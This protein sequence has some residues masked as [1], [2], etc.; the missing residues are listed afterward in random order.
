MS[1]LLWAAFALATP[2]F[3]APED[4]LDAATRPF[5][6]KAVSE[7]AAGR[8]GP[9]GQLYRMVLTSDPG[10]LPA[11]LGLGRSL[12]AVGDT[13][14]AEALYRSL[15][16][17][18]DAVEA[19]AQ[20][21]EARDPAEALALWRRLR[22]LRLG[23]SLPYRE[24]ARLLAGTEPLAAMAAY[25]TYVRLL[26]GAT[27]HG[28]T[29]LALGAALVDAGL[30]A[31][32]EQRWRAYLDAFPAGDVALEVGARLDRLEVERAA[33]S[34]TIGGSEP[35]PPEVLPRYAAAQAAMAAGD[36]DDAAEEG[37]A[38][39]AAAPRSAVAHALLAD[40]LV[41]L[42]AWEE[43]EVHAILACAL[44]P[45]DPS[46]RVRLGL[47]LSEAY[48]GRRDREAV[49][50]L[51]EAAVLR[52]GDT[53]VQL[54]LGRLEQ[55][56]GS[57]DPEGYVRAQA[58]YERALANGASGA[59]AAEIAAR[60]DA[61]RHTPPSPPDVPP[62]R[63]PHLPAE[64]LDH[65][66][67][68]SVYGRRGR[69]AE[70]VVELDAALAISPDAP[71]LLNKRAQL[72]GLSGAAVEP[73]LIRSL[74]ADP[75]QPSVLLDLAAIAHKRGDAAGAEQRYAQAAR[76]GSA[77]AHYELAALAEA[78]DDWA[79]VREQLAAYE[80]AAPGRASQKAPA[81]TRL[82]ERADARLWALRA[83]FGG[84]FALVVGLP[85]LFWAR[86]RTARTLRDLLDTAPE[87]W[88][89]A[90]RLL[91][92]L[93]HEVLKH[94][95]TVLPAVAEALARG[96]TAPWEAFSARAPT[97]LAHFRSYLAQLEALGRRHGK[98]LDLRRR[99][100]I[101]GPMHTALARLAR[102]RRPPRADDLHAL[103]ALINGDGYQ[104]IGRLVREI[105]VLPVTPER[106][107]DV[108]KRIVTEP[109][110]AGAPVPALGVVE[111]EQGLAV[112]MFRADFEDILANVLRNALAAGAQRLDV[113]LG[114]FDDPVT[115]HAWVEV[116]VVDDAP[117]S[118]T[119]AMIRGRYIGRGLGLAVDLIN[120]HGGSIRVDARP[121]GRKAVV[122][123]L[124][125]VE[126]A[127][128]E[129]EEWTVS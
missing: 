69:T 39:I 77:D 22:T 56:L 92:A 114:A 83:G 21:V 80:A 72:A 117:G 118:L 59:T 106:A 74:E 68:A 103:S 45:D 16:D 42:R 88:H 10:F 30:A 73:W 7:E 29:L 128:V 61:L 105:C 11:S 36:L 18:A 97:L 48:G 14:A 28:P 63:A 35:L 78:R 108:Y 82:R 1:W 107:Q 8:A 34:L 33:E 20:L 24:E 85:L 101:L 50:E 91:A 122:V 41:A 90:A 27:P 47:L 3:A 44:A 55:A 2:A 57:A 76:L 12:E 96:D 53:E 123:Q 86:Y 100:P 129:V 113:E 15:G 119:N 120:R 99:D 111:R 13:A 102:T 60:L 95:T 79:V 81:A 98:R 67:I 54:V 38:L 116:A 32:A 62:S 5:F 115:G 87:C 75:D 40:V 112:R 93:R 58:A 31:D 109:G 19:L 26:D 89:D 49:L 121:D 104:A 6:L 51:R 110:F 71:V 66:R 43:A 25:D 9:A 17:E 126:A 4:A 124:P 37:R 46:N 52:P 84:G 23:D 127:P 125:S 94:N 65:Y 70:A 64:A